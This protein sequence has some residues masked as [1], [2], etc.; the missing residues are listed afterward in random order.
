MHLG[1]KGYINNEKKDFHK[2]PSKG[3]E[4]QTL[5]SL[6][7]RLKKLAPSKNKREATSIASLSKGERL[8]P[9]ENE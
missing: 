5:K 2:N 7:P 6:L 9:K 8:N 4:L 1:E 3:L